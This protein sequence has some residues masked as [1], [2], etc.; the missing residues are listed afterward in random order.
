MTAKQ[1]LE[2][3]YAFPNGIYNVVMQRGVN[4]QGR[5]VFQFSP[6]ASGAYAAAVPSESVKQAVSSALDGEDH[7]Q[8]AT[9]FVSSWAL[10][11]SWHQQS[12]NYV[13]THGNHAFFTA[14]SN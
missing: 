6:V 12:L 4:S 9:F 3:A 11:G 14:T 7:S 10:E 1:Y 2:Q 5:T 13:L 8:G